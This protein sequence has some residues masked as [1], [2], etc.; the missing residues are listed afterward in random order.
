M[1]IVDSTIGMQRSPL[2][3]F[4]SIAD[5]GGVISWTPPNLTLIDSTVYFWR[6]A[7]DSIFDDPVKFTWQ[8]SS[9]MYVAG[10]TGFAQSHFYQFKSDQYEN[11]QYDTTNRKFN[12]VLNNK[13]LRVQTKGNP[14]DTT[15]VD[16]PVNA[17]GYYLNDAVIEYDGCETY[18]AVMIAVLDS[19]SLEPWNTCSNSFGQ[20]NE[21]V[22]TAGT[23][24]TNTATG[25][26]PGC[27]RTRPENYFIFRFNTPAQIQAI[28]NF[29]NQIP[30]GNYIIAYSWFNTQYSTADPGFA[31]AFTGLGF[32]MSSLQDNGP[33]TLFMKKGD[34]STKLE[35]FGNDP[36][37]VLTLNAQLSSKWNRGT[38]TSEIIGP[39]TRWE[40]LHWNQVPLE[41]PTTDNVYLNILGLNGL[42]NKW[43][44]L[45]REILYTTTGKD[46]SL[47]WISASDYK[48]LKLESFS[49]DDDMRTPAQMKYW[50]VYYD[51][52]PECA[53]NPNR[54]FYFYKN[55]I[56]EGDTIRMQIAIDNIG[57]LPM[58][59]LSMNFYLYDHNRLKHTFPILKLDSLR[60]GQFLIA[61]FVIDSTLGLAGGNSLWVEANP[62]GITH[63]PEKYHFNNLAEIK[64]DVNRDQINPI[65]DVTFDGVHILDGD[66]VSGKPNIS[67]QLHDENKFLALN[68]T[69]NFKVYVKGPNSNSYQRVYFN[70]AV[71]SPT[72]RFSAAVLP[73]NSCRIDWNPELQQDGIYV[74]EVEATDASKNESGKYNYKISF[75]V[76][77]RS[78]ITEILN[79]PNP[80]STSTRFVFTLTGNEVPTYM[81]IQVMTISGKIVREIM[82]N[83]LG[84]IHIGRNI[85]DYAWDGKD[86]YGD[87]LANGLY[88][89][90]VVSDIRGESI[91]HRE[92]DAD[93]YFKKGWGK[94][95]L[96]R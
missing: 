19:I 6:V 4:T 21:F 85:T 81:K 69:S 47:S 20:A 90:R 8:E 88:L 79:Y 37:D 57:N 16:L 61:S 58:D 33:F 54:S 78:T 46:T 74:F 24:G 48:F 31:S 82:Q 42:T 39:S 83:E 67:V 87:Q 23:C 5:S 25:Y 71:Y 26:I 38:T 53:L 45:S 68:D 63:Q 27:N 62:Q 15:G 91:E 35:Q 36:T 32:T 93:K 92:T 9:F 28:Q 7:N 66:I 51:E 10:K 30:N 72:M 29:V 55:P 11:V 89:Y 18:A 40:S 65:L 75:E 94:M 43:D 84:N 1:T 50:R 96:M 60:T 13:S 12:F 76:V 95:Y 44:T 3:R 59:S 70:S 64:F 56:S 14:Y 2:Y 86:E 52:V 80:F 22:L 77:N 73:K 49:R 17:V 41:S 34:P